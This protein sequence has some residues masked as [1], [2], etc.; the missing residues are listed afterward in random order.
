ME[1]WNID[2]LKVVGGSFGKFINM[3]DN[4]SQKVNKRV[5]KILVEIDS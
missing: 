5:V 4:F 2:T 3:E 1:L